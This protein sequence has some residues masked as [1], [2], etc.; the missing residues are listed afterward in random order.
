MKI[1]ETQDHKEIFSA[2]IVS[3]DIQNWSGHIV[4][5]NSEQA[6]DYGI[7][8]GDKNLYDSYQRPDGVLLGIWWRKWEIY[9]LG[10]KRWTRRT[11]FKKYASLNYIYFISKK[12]GF[13]LF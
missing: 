1:F 2:K 13:K 6:A 9:R 11:L 7:K 5:V 4:M 8:D 10:K 3:F 12:L